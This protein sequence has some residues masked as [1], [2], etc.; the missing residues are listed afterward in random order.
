M[1]VMSAIAASVLAV[2]SLG[3]AAPPPELKLW[4]LQCG[5]D[6][7][8]PMP[9]FSDT[10]SYEKRAPKP[11]TFSCYLI[12]HGDS[13]MIWDA[14]LPA[15]GGV[16]IVD[17][18]GQLGVS[19]S[20]IRYLGISHY[21]FDHIGQA[22]AFPDA[23][24]LIGA[25]DIAAVRKGD[26]LPDNSTDSAM[27]LAPWVSGGKPVEALNGDK[28]VFGDGRV[29]IVR[30]PGHTPGHQALLVQLAKGGNLL[31]SGDLYHFPENRANRNVPKFNTNRA[32]TLASMDRFEGLA[33]T[34]RA[35]VIIQH[36]LADVA[37][38]PR[39]PQAAE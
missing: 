22:A 32:D 27:R 23:T 4:R 13:Y 3:S 12:Q 38:L 19:P 33:R 1:K 6:Q 10:L 29:L 30:L 21:H 36:E 31:L 25:E 37:K 20:Q 8:L 39:F 16:A 14:G 18:L 35:K 34:M 2:L 17:Q 26:R 15:E 11:F 28:D 9:M 5:K 24:L 7:P